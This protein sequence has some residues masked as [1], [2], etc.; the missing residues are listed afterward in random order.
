[1]AGIEFTWTAWT[2]FERGLRGCRAGKARP[3]IRSLRERGTAGERN[4]ATLG[5]NERPCEKQTK[6]GSVKLLPMSLDNTKLS[7]GR[8]WWA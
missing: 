1:V 4:F 5:Q 8:E 6:T 7:G 2:D 3:L